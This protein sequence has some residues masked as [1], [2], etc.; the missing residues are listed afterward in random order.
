MQL[1]MKFFNCG[2]LNVITKSHRCDYYVQSLEKIRSKIIPH[3]D[4]FPLNNVKELDFENFKKSVLLYKE[5]GKIN[6]TKIKQII[7]SMNSKREL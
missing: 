2:S 7:N 5:D 4:L 3:F 6:T 1:F